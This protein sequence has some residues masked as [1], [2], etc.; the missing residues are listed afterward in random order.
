MRAPAR[1][2]LTVN[3]ICVTALTDCTSSGSSTQQATAV[4]PAAGAAGAGR[5]AR[6][7]DQHRLRGEG[8]RGATRPLR[9]AIG[10]SMRRSL[11]LC[12][13]LACDVPGPAETVQLPD[14]EP[15]ADY[16]VEAARAICS[17]MTFYGVIDWVDGPF[18]CGTEEEASGCNWPVTKGISITVS[19]RTTVFQSALAYELAHSCLHQGDTD[20]VQSLSE[21]IN[22]AANTAYVVAESAK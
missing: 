1:S 19:R 17:P 7:L 9:A 20:E 18:V 22:D 8:L 5:S 13:L 6:H 2:T 3:S 11:L 21:Q 10:L 15:G 16:V 14:A 12:T 4:V